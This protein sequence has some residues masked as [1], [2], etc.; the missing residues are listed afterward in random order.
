MQRCDNHRLKVVLI[1]NDD[2]PI[3]KWVN[4]KLT[5]LKMDYVYQQCYGRED[6][7][8]V[9]SKAEILWF[10]SARH[11]LVT[12]ENMDIFKNLR[13][14]VRVGSGT[15]NVDHEAC[16]KR[17]VVIAH[18]P[19]VVTEATSDHVIAMLFTA[20]RQTAGQDRLIRQGTWDARA[21]L[22]HGL[23]S[24]ADL[25]L[26]GFGRIGQAVVKKVSGFQMQV[27]VYDPYINAETVRQAGCQSVRFTNLLENSQFVLVVCPLTDET[28]GL[29]G[30]DELRRMRSDAVLVNCARG[31]IVDEEALTK[32]LQD[33]WIKAAAL[34]VVN[35]P[36]LQRGSALLSLPNVN[37]TPHYASYSDAYPDN[38]FMAGVE[39]ISELGSGKLPKWIANKEVKWKWEGRMATG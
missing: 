17:G 20:I 4:E 26:I 18:T 5:D 29:I 19:E 33:K 13:A 22:P 34:D 16:T 8:Q 15:D 2:H 37:V 39:A 11:G 30:E 21:A 3:P 28:K 25:G 9:A 27:R 12:E 35:D 23:I 32:A 14:V 31:G 38:L 24:G 36:P 7:E 10:M 6:L 1:A